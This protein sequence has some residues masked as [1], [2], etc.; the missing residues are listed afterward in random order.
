MNPKQVKSAF[1]YTMGIF[2][3]FPWNTFLNL[4]AYFVE[5]FDDPDISKYYTFSFF[6]FALLSMKLSIEVDQRFDIFTSSKNLF[7]VVV[8]SFNLI[9]FVCQWLP[10]NSFKYGLF[11]FVVC[12]LSTS[13]FIY[14]V[15]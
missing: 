12:L 4:N 11:L 13:H 14:D 6:V 10:I 8:I 5:A 2:S 7:F 9:Y 3:I 15:R 1:F